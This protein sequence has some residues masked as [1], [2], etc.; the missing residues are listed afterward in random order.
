MINKKHKYYS[1][2]LTPNNL[3]SATKLSIM[4]V[5]ITVKINYSWNIINQYWISHFKRKLDK[6]EYA[7]G[8]QERVVSGKGQLTQL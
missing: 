6:S 7:Q 3:S 8:R 4:V 5:M 2:K 1:E